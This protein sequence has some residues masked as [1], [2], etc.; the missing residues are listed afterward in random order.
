MLW[1]TTV[2]KGAQELAKNDKVQGFMKDLFTTAD[3]DGN[4]S[5]DASDMVI[6]HIKMIAS[7]WGYVANADG[8]MSEEEEEKIYG[9]MNSVIFEGTEK[10]PPLLTDE[11]MKQTTITKKDIKKIVMEH[12]Q[13]P[14]PLKKVVQFA[15][16]T[17]TEEVFYTQAFLVANADG[18]VGTDERE[19]LEKFAEMLGITKFEIKQIE[20]KI[21]AEN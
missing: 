5:V 11:I 13:N 7:V 9:L 17:E 4:G 1:I 6:N 14:L 3:A 2:L 18:L 19:L 10:K 8:T 16:I 15:E 21:L 12:I 20:K